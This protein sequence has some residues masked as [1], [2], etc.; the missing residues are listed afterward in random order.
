[1][2]TKH[3]LPTGSLLQGKYK[4]EE[5]LGQGGF[6]ITYLALHKNLNKKVAIKELFMNAQN[7]VCTRSESD[8]AGVRPHFDNFEV[9]KNRFMQEAQTLAKFSGKR[10]IVQISDIFEENNTVYFVMDFIEGQPLSQIVKKRGISYVNQL[11]KSGIISPEEAKNHSKKNG[12]P[13]SESEA[14][15][16]AMQILEA[17]KFVHQEGILHRDI[18]PDNLIVRKEDNQITLIDFGIAREYVE[19]ETKTQTAMLT[20]GY[21]PPEQRLSKTKRNASL[22]LYSVGAVLYYCLTG[23]RPQTTDEIAMDGYQ[24]A[25]DHNPE[26]SYQLNAVIDKAI[27]KRPA[28]RFQSAEE[29]IEALENSYFNEKDNKSTYDDTTQVFDEPHISSEVSPSAEDLFNLGYQADQSQNYRE[30]FKYYKQAADMGYADAQCNLGVY[31]NNGTAIEQ[32]LGIAVFW[33]KKAARLGEPQAQNNLGAMFENGSGT[34][35]DFEEA[36]KWYEKAANQGHEDGL[37][38]YQRLKQALQKETGEE[39]SDVWAGIIGIAILLL[40]VAGIGFGVYKGY[41][42]LNKPEESNSNSF[43]NSLFEGSKVELYDEVFE[44]ND[45]LLS[46]VNQLKTKKTSFNESDLLLIVGFK[47]MGGSKYDAEKIE[48][49]RY[50]FISQTYKKHNTISKSVYVGFKWISDDL[51][52]YF[53]RGFENE[54]IGNKITSHYYNDFPI[55][56]QHYFYDERNQLII[57]KVGKQELWY[58]YDFNSSTNV[59]E[60]LSIYRNLDEKTKF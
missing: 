52:V 26:I 25:Q 46:I 44:D 57:Y 42:W 41:E 17:L 12:T 19:D 39:E 34:Q 48:D 6:G 43:S 54:Q 32:N 45:E 35:Q 49:Y 9:F 5:V 51:Y 20:I 55:L 21:A 33:Y 29:F 59:F 23:K 60:S 11:L 58:F 38:N 27:K 2:N 7:V 47:S 10:G 4:I 56:Q 30:A 18:K 1:M 16:Y 13:L 37:K 15:D 28:E 40:I 14:I 36:L 31:Y 24:S 3:H 53:R 22:D 50:D 8:N